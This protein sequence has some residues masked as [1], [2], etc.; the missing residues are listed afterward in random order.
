MRRLF[1]IFMLL[2]VP[3]QLSWSA[4]TVY[5]QHEN[6]PKVMHFGH[7]SHEH[8]TSNAVAKGDASK[9]QASIDSDCGFCHLSGMAIAPMPAS[10]ISFNAV[11]VPPEMGDNPGLTPIP[12][13]R[14]ER[15]Q[16]TPAVS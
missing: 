11:L 5:C 4:A 10:S 1:V 9:S 16:W 15:P 14:P 13:S 12:P 7:H 3:F 2:V 8:S 6:N